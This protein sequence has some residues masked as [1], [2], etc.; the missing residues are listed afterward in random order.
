MKICSKCGVEKDFSLFQKDI[1]KNDGLSC[2][3]KKCRKQHY[4]NNRDKI[5]KKQN[6]YSNKNKDKKLQYQK[7][8]LINNRDKVNEYIRN[9]KKNDPS[10]KLRI[11]VSGAVCQALKSNTSKKN[12][13]SILKYL[14]YSMIE[15]KSHL[16]SQFDSNMSWDNHGTYWHIDHIYP[17]SL[18][19]YTSMEDENFKKCWSLDNLRPLEKIQNIK[20]GN[21][22]CLSRS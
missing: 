11:G 6:E 16:E 7:Q 14:P 17:Q 2:S 15:L 12:G 22:L 21:K 10:F 18:L 9:R 4:L 3:C 8:Y 20:K 5:L 19:P 13:N 1:H